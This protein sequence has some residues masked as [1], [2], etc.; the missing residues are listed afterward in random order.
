MGSQKKNKLTALKK[1]TGVFFLSF[2]S[3]ICNSIINMLLAKQEDYKS[4]NN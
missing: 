4:W 3:T 2:Y 1:K